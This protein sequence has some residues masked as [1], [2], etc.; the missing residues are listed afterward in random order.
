MNSPNVYVL[1]VCNEL[2]PKEA[3]FDARSAFTSYLTVRIQP[4]GRN[5]ARLT[6]RIEPKYQKESRQIVLEFLNYLL[7]RSVQIM[8]EKKF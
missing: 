4:E 3:V 6:L 5:I 8:S 2:Y 7:D 1:D